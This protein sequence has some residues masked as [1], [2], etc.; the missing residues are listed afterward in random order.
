M[1]N[2]D[3]S[4]TSP[5]LS[6]DTRKRKTHGRATL[7][8]V[9][10]HAGVTTMT[11]SRTLREPQR[12]S[13]QTAERVN[14]AL[15]Q[16]GYTPNKSAG[17]LASGRS[18][19]VAA[20]I[21]NI[22]NALFAE[23]IQGLSDALQGDNLE[24]LLAATG[25]SLEREEHQIRAVLGW[26]PAALVVT[27]R[28]HTD[29]ALAMMRR[30][31]SEGTPVIEMWDHAPRQAEFI[32]V[33]FN[34]RQAGKSMFDHLL[35]CGYREL[36]YVDSGVAGDVRAHER[37][38]G[39]LGAAS[40]A[41]IQARLISAPQLDPMVAGRQVLQDLLDTGMLPHAIAFSN[42][43]FAAGACLQA[44]DRGIDIPARLGLM[45]FGDMPIACQ[46]GGGISTLAVPRYRIGQC[47]GERVLTEIA[48]GG[49]PGSPSPPVALTPVLTPRLVARQTTRRVPI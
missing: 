9:A 26:A 48:R 32:Q 27:G 16:T 30:A 35:A 38:Q 17:L 8:D 36:V 44:L 20:L 46:L 2:P 11:V 1:T 42:D 47:T 33:G 19:I 49:K 18:R 22:S 6:G 23:T 14:A 45:G 10:R 4:S 12:V 5:K 41:K 43:Q 39:F 37:R 40:R 13:A 25:Y 29:A 7:A 15:L 31:Q 24:L 28:H 34:H 3:K 21:P